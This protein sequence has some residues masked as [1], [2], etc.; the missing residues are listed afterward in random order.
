MLS[1]ALLALGA[2]A[3]AP[4]E[5]DLVA[6]Q[7]REGAGLGARLANALYGCALAQVMSA[8]VAA[9]TTGTGTGYRVAAWEAT[10][11]DP[12]GTAILLHYTAMRLASDLQ[13]STGGSRSIWG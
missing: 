3:E 12:E 8:E 5:A 6:A 11:G 1:D 13:Q 7:A 10:G 4:S 9:S 2:Y